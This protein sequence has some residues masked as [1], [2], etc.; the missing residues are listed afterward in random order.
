MTKCYSKIRKIH[1]T[2]EYTKNFRKRCKSVCIAMFNHIRTIITLFLQESELI[3][4]GN[5]VWRQ[6]TKEKKCDN[7]QS[8]HCLQLETYYYYVNFLHSNDTRLSER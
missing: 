7:K 6:V 1:G 8:L 2:A 5:A 4:H 3:E